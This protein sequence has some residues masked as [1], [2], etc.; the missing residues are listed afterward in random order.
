MLSVLR[1]LVTPRSVGVY[2]SVN[3]PY[4]SVAQ[5]MN[6]QKISTEHMYFLDCASGLMGK[7]PQE[8]EKAYILSGPH[9]L[10]EL[11]IT[12]SKL[13]SSEKVKGKEN[14]TI[15]FLDSVST[16]LLYNDQSTV[17]K[18]LHT[19]AG[20]VRTHNIRG[21]F[22]SLQQDAASGAVASTTQFHDKVLHIA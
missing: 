13:L 5:I 9:S 2:I 11:N 12:L 21:V 15:L 20:K 3:K 16:F 4:F 22:F 7:P 17:A 14:D 1:N 6:N 19:I 18:F 8:L 10:T